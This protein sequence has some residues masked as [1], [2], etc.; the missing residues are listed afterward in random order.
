MGND[1]YKQKI[2]QAIV[3]NIDV[4]EAVFN[5]TFSTFRLMRK[6]LEEIVQEYNFD[7]PSDKY[8]LE[9][10]NRSKYELEL[11]IGSDTMIFMLQPYVFEIEKKNSVWQLS[12]LQDN[13]NTQF[14]GIITIYNFLSDSIKYNRTEDLGYLIGRIFINKDKHFFVEG[15]GKMAFVANDFM[16]EV[17]DKDKVRKLIN[18]AI[19]YCLDFHLLAPPYDAVN[20]VTV[21]QLQEKIKHLQPQVTRLGFRLSNESDKTTKPKYEK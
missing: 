5:H 18:S 21:S 20:V 12:Y 4:K 3:T 13:K 1:D 14:S 7:M 19:L 15:K 8:H 9:F 16:N 6:V 17:V 10:R 11:K 2:V